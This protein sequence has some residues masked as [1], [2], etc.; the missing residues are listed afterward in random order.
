MQNDDDMKVASMAFPKFDYG[1]LTSAYSDEHWVK[2][3]EWYW[4]F[5]VLTPNRYHGIIV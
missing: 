4:G 5:Q 2:M 3:A 1:P